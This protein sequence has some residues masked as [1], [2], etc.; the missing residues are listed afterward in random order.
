MHKNKNGEHKRV[1][2]AD[3]KVAILRATHGG[4][5]ASHFGKNATLSKISDNYYWK[6]KQCLLCNCN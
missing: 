4:P 5:G 6:G 1:V 2:L 3:E